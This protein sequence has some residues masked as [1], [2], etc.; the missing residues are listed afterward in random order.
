ML[1]IFDY[2]VQMIL[3]EEKN[4]MNLPEKVKVYLTLSCLC[5][6]KPLQNTCHDIV[7]TL[8]TQSCFAVKV[9]KT[10]PANL[11]QVYVG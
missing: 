1:T 10:T 4:A 6:S 3:F 9:L 8:T 2:S 11:V 5:R 7:E